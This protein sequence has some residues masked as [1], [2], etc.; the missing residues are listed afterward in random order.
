M[1]SIIYEDERVTEKVFE[2][3]IAL[4]N[5]KSKLNQSIFNQ[6]KKAGIKVENKSEYHIEYENKDKEAQNSHYVVTRTYNK[7][8]PYKISRK[9]IYSGNWTIDD[10]HASPLEQ[11]GKIIEMMKD[12]GVNVPKE[13]EIEIGYDK[14][15]KE[16][17]TAG[18]TVYR[19]KKERVREAFKISDQLDHNEKIQKIYEELI[20]LREKVSSSNDPDEISRLSN[21]IVEVSD[22]LDNLVNESRRDD[23]IPFEKTLE[24]IDSEMNSIQDAITVHMKEYLDSYER[25]KQLLGDQTEGLKNTMNPEEFDKKIQELIHEKMAE[26]EESL[27][28]RAQIDNEVQELRKL[29][30]KRD[31]IKRDYDTAVELGL[32]ALEYK[33]ITDNFRS[34]KLVN[35]IIDKK[36][37]GDII[38]I[39]Y[40]ERT[41]EQKRIIKAIRKEILNELIE[42]KKE[43]EE[44]SVLNL[45]EAL[46][47]IEAE[48]HLLGKQRVLIIKPS[49]LEN[50][51]KN[52]SKMPEKIKVVEKVDLTYQPGE[53]PDDMKEVMERRKG[54]NEKITFYRDKRFPDKVFVRENVFDRFNIFEVGDP[55]YVDGALCFEVEPKDA[56]NILNNQKNDYSPYFIEFEDTEI[57]KDEVMPYGDIVMPYGDIVMPYVEKEKVEEKDEVMPF[58]DRVIPYV[59]RPKEEENVVE[60]DK[61]VEDKN[62]YIPGTNFKKPRDR[63]VNETDAEYI[64]YLKIYYDQIFGNKKKEESAKVERKKLTERYSIFVDQEE[65]DHFYARR[66]AFERFDIDPIG[67]GVKVAGALCYPIDI[68]D[69]EAIEENAN[70]DYSPYIVERIPIRIVRR[71]VEVDKIDIFKDTEDAKLYTYKNVIDKYGLEPISED[72]ML[73]EE[74]G[75]EIKAED[76]ERLV[77][78]QYNK[79]YPYEIEFK[80]ITLPKENVEAVTFSDPDAFAEGDWVIDPTIS[81]DEKKVLLKEML[82]NSDVELPS[83]DE[84]DIHFEDMGFDEETGGVKSH[85]VLYKKEKEVNDTKE[86]IEENKEEDIPIFE[87]NVDTDIPVVEETTTP[88]EV[89]EK[90]PI[91]RIDIYKDTEDGKFYAYKPVF[92]RFN[93]EPASDEVKVNGIASFR[94]NAEDV[95]DIMNN[96]NN[97][98]SPYSVVVSNSDVEKV[99]EE[100]TVP[101]TEPETVP[102]TES[103]TVPEVE[104]EEE[105]I[106]STETIPVVEEVSEPIEV[107]EPVTVPETEPETVPETEPEAEIPTVPETEAPTE[108]ETVPETEPETEAPTEP[109]TVPETEPVE[110]EIVAPI[111][112][113]D[114]SLEEGEESTKRQKTEKITLFR[115]L[116]DNNQVYAPDDVLDRFGIKTLAIPTMIQDMPC[117]KISN[118]TN[119][120]INSIAKMSKG[121]K[122]KINYID[123]QIKDL[124]NVVVR[125]HVEDILDKVTTNLDIRAKDVKRYKS[126]NLQIA[127]GFREELHSGNFAYNIVHIVPAIIRAGVGFYRKLSSRLI[128]SPRAIDAMRTIEERLGRL[129]S[130]ELDVLFDEYRG[131][132]LKTDMNNQ[133]NPLILDRLKQY[134]MGRVDKLNDVVR[135]D[136]VTLFTL[137]GQ[138]KALEEKIKKTGKDT[139]SLENKR[140]ELMKEAS[141]H[142]RSIID[143][144]KKADTLLSGGVHGI[145]EDFKAVSTKLNYVGLRF[146]KTNDF[147]NDLQ[148]QLGLLGRR[149]NTALA[150]NDDEA[151]VQNFMGLESCYYKN[152]EIRGSLAGKRSVGSKYYSPVAEQ[153]D[154]RDDPFI[155][156]LF[157]TVA[158]TSAAISA[159]NAIRV[160]QIEGKRITNEQEA[161]ANTVNAQNNATMYYA[162]KTGESIAG[163]Q[164]T[165]QNGIEAQIRQDVLTNAGVRERANLDT[166]NWTFNNAYRAA[167]AAGH[168]AYNQFNIDVTNQINAVTADYTQGIINQ[169]EA[170]SRMAEISNG[171]HVT[172]NSV[173]QS[174]LDILK[175]YAATHPQFDLTAVEQSMEYLVAHPN[176]IADMNQAIVETSNLANSLQDLHAMPMVALSY[177]PSD[178]ESTIICATSAALLAANVSNTMLRAQEKKGT[179]GNDITDMMEDYLAGGD[180]EGAKV[181]FK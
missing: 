31:R 19:V 147:D 154:Y 93:I 68:V 25:I 58:Y 181:N 67:E 12:A 18:F 75:A 74:V 171:A 176:A 11:R 69:V 16:T 10:L 14:V 175:P 13:D 71:K 42:A 132:Q 22:V 111:V 27:S 79:K 41:P 128:S 36:G 2:G 122:L 159:I 45:V 97:D 156:D 44:K 64:K 85:Y 177:L 63:K 47:G 143:N 84:L 120:I 139:G 157:T 104:V 100:T 1:E 169:A 134:G 62:E 59:E 123:V 149:L 135:K 78:N 109:E 66:Y 160:H 138:I 3:D 21:R 106:A 76:V 131:S 35:A 115:D 96:Q 125:P 90:E 50:I 49:S 172:L 121:P 102:E 101:E 73:N 46:Y 144:R 26:N 80:N 164:E 61:V 126:S 38:K 166:T 105:K 53:V 137:L 7:K 145:E 23:Y 110:E 94:V 127:K 98:Y 99:V 86:E 39:P 168:A 32:S 124:G 29:K 82:L 174:S 158:V 55:V 130:D 87:E 112:M 150:T 148:H 81:D 72:V 129:D 167:D 4:N 155:R 52:A 136:Y 88:A 34:R 57:Q 107:F 89:Q 51:R 70:N 95:I 28:V 9:E 162:N 24:E 56:E 48:A 170:L 92:E 141:V 103:E 60:E 146:A 91:E 40:K 113:D 118:D 152:T 83:D 114:T 180:I 179:Y 161:Q 33:E 20:S 15:N 165:F 119:Q 178:M 8:V 133:I 37:L 117:H 30:K 77:A 17:A 43:N 116:N 6:M 153:F 65:P 140:K 142:V 108:P 5:K 163:K 151:I 54:L 173:I